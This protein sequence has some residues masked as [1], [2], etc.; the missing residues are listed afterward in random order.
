LHLELGFTYAG[1]IH[2]AG[3]KFGRWLDLAFYELELRTPAMPVDG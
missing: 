2:H 1:T 3:F